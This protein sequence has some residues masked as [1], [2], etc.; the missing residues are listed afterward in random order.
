MKIFPCLWVVVFVEQRVITVPAVSAHLCWRRIPRWRALIFK[1]LEGSIELVTGDADVAPMQTLTRPPMSSK[2]VE[3]VSGGVDALTIN[4]GAIPAT[5]F[6]PS[7]SSLPKRRLS[8]RPAAECSPRKKKRPRMEKRPRKEKHPS[9]RGAKK[10]PVIAGYVLGSV[11]SVR[12]MLRIRGYDPDSIS[13]PTPAERAEQPGY[14]FTYDLLHP[15]PG[16]QPLVNI[17]AI[18]RSLRRHMHNKLVD[19]WFTERGEILETTI[20]TQ[21]FLTEP[22]QLPVATEGKQEDLVRQWLES[23]GEALLTNT[24][25]THTQSFPPGVDK[26]QYAWEVRGDTRDIHDDD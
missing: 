19:V 14:I 20:I 15:K 25:L 22:D 24:P 1:W 12:L 21:G 9:P 5:T 11:A 8:P 18:R 13:P 6:R 10:H 4:P 3:R 7:S 2:E 17:D 26:S 23:K 16:H